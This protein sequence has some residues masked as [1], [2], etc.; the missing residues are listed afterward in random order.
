MQ[1]NSSMKFLNATHM[2]AHRVNPYEDTSHDN[3][4]IE[5]SYDEKQVIVSPD[6][7]RMYENVNLNSPNLG[8]T[9][10]A[11]HDKI[12]NGRCS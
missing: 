11:D 10:F 1:C 12:A 4:R 5:N 7:M 8:T 6:G 9:A 3:I 2:V